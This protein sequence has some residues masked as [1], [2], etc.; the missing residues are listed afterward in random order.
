MQWPATLIWASSSSSCGRRTETFFFLLGSRR[1]KTSTHAYTTRGALFGRFFFIWTTT[2]L[3]FIIFTTAFFCSVLSSRVYKIAAAECGTTRRLFRAHT[4]FFLNIKTNFLM[5]IQCSI[6]RSMTFLVVIWHF[7][8]HW[9]SSIST[10]FFF[11]YTQEWA[12]AGVKRTETH[13]RT[14]SIWCM[15]QR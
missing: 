14:Q 8:T 5:E 3:Y 7:T 15:K 11:L 4:H 12:L 1:T 9:S 13:T 2:A 10:L 6:V